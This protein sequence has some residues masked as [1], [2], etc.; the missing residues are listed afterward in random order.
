MLFDFKNK[1]VFLATPKAASTSIE[2]MLIDMPKIGSLSGINNLKHASFDQFVQI[3]GP[4][5]VYDF[6][7][8]CVVRHPVD[9]AISWFNYRSRKQAKH[10]NRYL[11]DTSF[12]EY[13]LSLEAGEHKEMDDT[14]FVSSKDGQRADLIFALDDTKQWQAFLNQ[15]YGIKENLHMNRSSNQG[16]RY[17]PTEEEMAIL[18]DLLKWES[19]QYE[20]LNKTTARQAI[21]YLADRRKS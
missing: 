18:K 11:G 15:V 20:T 6:T 13:L 5:N 17:R 8:W 1:L 3:R 14:I 12:A 19:E 10:T 4:L 2:Q 16:R 21:Q 9:K 7:T